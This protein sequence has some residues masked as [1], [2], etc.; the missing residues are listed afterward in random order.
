[1]KGKNE[2][3]EHHNLS[4][5]GPRCNYAERTLFSSHSYYQDS[6]YNESPWDIQF[7]NYCFLFGYHIYGFTF[8]DETVRMQ[9]ILKLCPVS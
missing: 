1:M 3:V 2:R 4:M 5:Y 6:F 8:L 7:F 9:F